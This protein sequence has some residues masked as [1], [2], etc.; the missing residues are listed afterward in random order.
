VQAFAAPPLRIDVI[1][2]LFSSLSRPNRSAS[3]LFPA[4]I[5]GRRPSADAHLVSSETQ[6]GPDHVAGR[7]FSVT[8]GFTSRPLDGVAVDL[9]NSEAARSKRCKATRMKSTHPVTLT[10]N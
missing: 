5:T 6:I 8:S 10:T 2:V 9:I 4:L 7:R 3:N 1:A